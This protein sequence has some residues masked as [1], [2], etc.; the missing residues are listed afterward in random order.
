MVHFVSVVVCG[1]RVV[2]G[3]EVGVVGRVVVFV[4]AKEILFKFPCVCRVRVAFPMT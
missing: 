4:G 2:L 3:E 1:S